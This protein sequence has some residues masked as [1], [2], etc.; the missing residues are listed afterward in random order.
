MKPLTHA[1]TPPSAESATALFAS[2]AQGAAA[3]AGLRLPLP[4]LASLQAD[5]LTEATRLWNTSLVPTAEP[6]HDAGGASA[7]PG[8]GSRTVRSWPAST[9]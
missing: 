1:L 3:V 6:S 2:V 9:C 4:L 7:R 8:P 5:Y